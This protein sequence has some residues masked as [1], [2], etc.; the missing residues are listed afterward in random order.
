MANGARGF[1]TWLHLGR[2]G[3]MNDMLQ[4]H[5]NADQWIS[6]LGTVVKVQHEKESLCHMAHVF[7]VIVFM[8]HYSANNKKSKTTKKPK[9]QPGSNF[10]PPW[11]VHHSKVSLSR[12]T[13][14]ETEL[15][16]LVWHLQRQQLL[17]HLSEPVVV[18]LV[19]G[20][21]FIKTHQHLSTL[22]EWMCF[23]KCIPCQWQKVFLWCDELTAEQVTN[24]DIWLFHCDAGALQHARACWVVQKIGR[25]DQSAIRW[26]YWRFTKHREWS[27]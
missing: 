1:Q 4:M 16:Y 8:L 11:I 20:W 6:Q 19:G 21:V 10:P 22:C 24:V 3:I 18:C 5:R 15:H 12:G 2:H 23:W 7:V 26:T 14:E 27:D 9:S 25:S 13:A 17:L